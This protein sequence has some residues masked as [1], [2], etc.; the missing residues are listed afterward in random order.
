MKVL[1][2]INSEYVRDQQIYVGTSLDDIHD[3]NEYPHWQDA[4]GAVVLAIKDA[5]SVQAA[6]AEI[7]AFYGCSPDRFTGFRLADNAELWIP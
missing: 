6:I 4:S 2:C 3:E 5:D 7:A 1:I